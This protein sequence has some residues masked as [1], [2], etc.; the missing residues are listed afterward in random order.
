[1]K[2]IEQLP[3]GAAAEQVSP[4]FALTVTVPVGNDAPTT[5]ATLKP[6]TTGVPVLAGFGEIDVIVVVLDACVTVSETFF[7]AIA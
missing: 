4:V 6:T 7:D 2:V 5:P 1:V 3:D